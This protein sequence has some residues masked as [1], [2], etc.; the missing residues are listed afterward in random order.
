MRRTLTIL[1]AAAAVLGGQTPRELI[2]AGHYKRALAALGGRTPDAESLYCMATIKEAA[3]EL[4][5]AE[6][7]A[8]SD[9]TVNPKEAQYHYRLSEIRVS[10]E[11]MGCTLNQIGLVVRL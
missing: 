8:E 10:P 2:E 4:E 1:L 7:F 11:R 6:K 5:A 3:G 9:Y